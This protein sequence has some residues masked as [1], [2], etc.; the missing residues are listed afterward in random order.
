M[1]HVSIFRHPLG[2]GE[3]EAGGR[4]LSSDAS[5]LSSA[6]RRQAR[7]GTRWTPT[8]SATQ[9]SAVVNVSIR[10]ALPRLIGLEGKRMRII[11]HSI[12]IDSFS[13]LQARRLE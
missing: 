2:R 7:W 3:A 9:H 5:G 4:N 10:G 12:Y 13:Q 11:C 6:R 1:V 8:R